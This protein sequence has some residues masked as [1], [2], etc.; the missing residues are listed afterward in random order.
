MVWQNY[1][2]TVQGSKWNKQRQH[3]CYNSTHQNTDH[4]RT[5]Y[6]L[7]I[8]STFR[9]MKEKIKF[10]YFQDIQ[11]PLQTI[12]KNLRSSKRWLVWPAGTSRNRQIAEPPL[13]RI[14]VGI[15]SIFATSRQ[16]SPRSW[17]KHG[18]KK[19]IMQTNIICMRDMFTASTYS[20]PRQAK[21]SFFRCGNRS[22][23][24]IR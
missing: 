1:F 24:Q 12:T 4:N 16:H 11:A 5:P 14:E 22:E 8:T 9:E 7:K 13:L 23:G 6:S 10:H 19:V 3:K 18:L 17:C 21:V 2:R 20:Q 15:Q